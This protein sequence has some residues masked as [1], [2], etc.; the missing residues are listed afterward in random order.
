MKNF[1]ASNYSLEYNSSSYS[2]EY[3]SIRF[4]VL[5]VYVD[6]PRIFAFRMKLKIGSIIT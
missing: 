5:S 4:S 3:N 1:I 6:A 2:I